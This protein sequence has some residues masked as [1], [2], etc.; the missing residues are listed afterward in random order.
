MAEAA[1]EAPSAS[2]VPVHSSVPDKLVDRFERIRQRYASEFEGSSP[3]FFV[4]AP[5]RVNLIGEHIDYHGYRYFFPYL[6]IVAHLI[7][8]VCFLSQLMQM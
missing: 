8:A 7:V 6:T 4:R 5:G 3:S 1:V 2:I